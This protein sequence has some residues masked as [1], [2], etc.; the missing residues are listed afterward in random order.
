[1]EYFDKNR[2]V[3][4]VKNGQFKFS[5]KLASKYISLCSESLN[6]FFGKRLSC[7]NLNGGSPVNVVSS[8]KIKEEPN[9]GLAEN[10][11]IYSPEFISIFSAVENGQLDSTT[12]SNEISAEF[13]INLAEFNRKY[14]DKD[15][16][17]LEKTLE[18]LYAPIVE[19]PEPNPEKLNDEPSRMHSA[20]MNTKRLSSSRRGRF[21]VRLDPFRS[22]MPNSSRQP[23]IH[24]DEFLQFEALGQRH[25]PVGGKSR[26]S[27][28]HLNSGH[29]SSSSLGN[30]SSYSS[31]GKHQEYMRKKNL[32]SHH[33]VHRGDSI[34]GPYNE[35][36]ANLK[37][38]LI[39]NAS[40]SNTSHYKQKP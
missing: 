16:G 35:Y 20:P 21:G 30:N 24:I 22:R 36:Y 31:G 39:G 5:D 8:G 26:S 29:S 6:D 3:I 34:L 4:A 2:N 32:S 1:M 9:E 38:G 17:S 19:P 25:D 10:I 14:C 12:D 23:S 15:P 13:K 33:T 11:E 18:V 40:A 28:L 27:H 37:G 7:G